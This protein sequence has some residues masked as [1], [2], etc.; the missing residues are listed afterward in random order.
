MIV[1][2]N[3]QSFDILCGKNV[4]FLNP[5]SFSVVVEQPQVFNSDFVWFSDGFLICKIAKIFGLSLNRYSMDFT[6]LAEPLFI[7]CKNHN[8]KFGVIGSDQNSVDKFSSVIS[9]IYGIDVSLASNGYLNEQQM[10]D[11]IDEL[12]ARKIDIILVGLG[13]PLQE[14]FL[15]KARKKGWSGTGFTC[16]GFITQTAMSDKHYYPKIIDSLG[17]RFLYR[18]YKEP[19]TIKR[20][21][22]VYPTQIF[23]I[24]KAF[25][26]GEIKVE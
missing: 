10:N 16:G 8:L 17:L 24:A 15:I 9:D 25:R 3:F 26:C 6:S 14:S 18:M 21:L 11:F 20:Y 19:H 7:Y 4:S 13:T 1:F 2:K 12:I 23:R 5:F 22:T